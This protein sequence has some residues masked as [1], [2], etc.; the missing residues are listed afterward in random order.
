MLYGIERMPDGKRKAGLA[1]A[2]ERIFTQEFQA[3]ILPFD[4]QT[5]PWFAIISAAREAAGHAISQMDAMIAAIARQHRAT[6]A[7][8][9]AADFAHCGIRVINP[10]AA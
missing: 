8:R 5:S 10:W 1:G 3:R 6:L 4:E 9:N 2:V 7:T